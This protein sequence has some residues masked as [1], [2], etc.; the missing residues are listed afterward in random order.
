MTKRLFIVHGWD[1]YPEEGWFP[2]LKTECEK[3]SFEVYIPQLPNPSEPRID[4]W[5][6]A[7]VRAVGQLDD[8]TYF[9]GH[10][11]GCQAI[12]RYLESAS[13]DQKTGGAV[14]VAGFL[15]RLHGLEDDNIVR[16]VAN[17][18]MSMPLNLSHVKT[19][20]SKSVAIFSNNDPFVPLDNQEKF[21]DEL[22]SEIIVVNNA[23]HFSGARDQ[24]FALP[25]V[26]Q[27]LIE[28]S[29]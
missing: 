9:V 22:D 21:R 20:L 12:V 13:S 10:S 15:T 8:H 29:S 26:I 6:P 7:L 1:G 4:H 23:G 17:E 5:V 18:W 2:W 11:M 16:D 27:K 19:Q 3:Q 24:C 25:L 28:I 14:F